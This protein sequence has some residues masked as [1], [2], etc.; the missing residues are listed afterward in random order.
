MSHDGHVVCAVPGSEA[1]EVFF[2]GY[3]EDPVD[4]VL[5][6][7]MAAHRIGESLGREGTRGDVVAPLE[8][9]LFSFLDLGF[10]QTDEGQ[11]GKALRA[12]KGTVRTYPVDAV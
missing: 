12:G 11:F 10:D 3:V 9:G 8:A 5:D 4:A 6:A 1:R 2:E 7:P